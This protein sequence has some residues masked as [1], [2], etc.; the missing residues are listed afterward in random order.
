MNFFKKIIRKLLIKIKSYIYYK[1]V[2][3]IENSFCEISDEDIVLISVAFNN[4]L[5]IEYQIKLINKYLTG[6]FFYIIADNST[7]NSESTKIELLCNKYKISYLKLPKYATSEPSVSHGMSLN[8]LYRN[9][10]Q[11]INITKFGFLDHD[12]FPIAKCDVVEMFNT[13]T[14]GCYGVISR[15][16]YKWYLWAGF[17]FFDLDKLSSKSLNFLPSDGVDTGGSNWDKIYKFINSESIDCSIEKKSFFN[18]EQDRIHQLHN[19][20]LINNCWIHSVN[21]SNWFG[22]NDENEKAKENKLVSL[23]HSYLE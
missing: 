18:D 16:S 13:N 6:S 1:S 17:C 10:I 5:V 11:K 20:E 19:Y 9:V 8:W 2:P 4:S 7:N 14:S 23:M 22:N 12:V 3:L 15:R 21:A